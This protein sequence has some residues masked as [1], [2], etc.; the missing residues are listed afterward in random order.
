MSPGRARHSRPGQMNGDRHFSSRGGDP[1]QVCSPHTCPRK[2]LLVIPK[3]R[4][5][6]SP[7]PVPGDAP[8]KFIKKKLCLHPSTAAIYETENPI[9]SCN[10][11]RRETTK[12]DVVLVIYITDSIRD[13]FPL[14]KFSAVIISLQFIENRWVPPNLNFIYSFTLP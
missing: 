5:L 10:K 3:I 7:I 2:L 6:L 9:A 14:T 11:N 4:V 8:R 1:R 12:L 13:A